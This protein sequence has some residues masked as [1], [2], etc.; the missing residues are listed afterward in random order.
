MPLAERLLA[1][2]RVLLVDIECTCGLGVA[3]ERD[4]QEVIEL[5]LCMDGKAS[6]AQ[7]GAQL[8][9]YVRPSYTQ[10][11][12]FCERLTGISDGMLRD[13]PC[14]KPRMEWLERALVKWQPELWASWGDFDREQVQRECDRL[15]V[16]NPLATLVHINAK[17]AL[18]RHLAAVAESR[19][20]TFPKGAKRGV[21]IGR[22]LKFLGLE[23]E[24]RQHCGADDAFNMARVIAGVRRFQMGESLSGDRTPSRSM[25]A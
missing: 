9:A 15:G 20:M 19:A 3:N 22:A 17:R 25:H 10:V 16:P 4:V 18:A 21:G 6:P 12:A 7:H 23:F 2:N 11:N 14:F 24:G 13:E 1:S 8:S 5:G